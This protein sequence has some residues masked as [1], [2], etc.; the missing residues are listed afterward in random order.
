[1]SKTSS[2]GKSFSICASAYG[3]GIAGCC[4]TAATA[5]TSP[6]TEAQAQGH[7]D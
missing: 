6:T 5:A 7:N 4:I 2:L 1:M 3:S